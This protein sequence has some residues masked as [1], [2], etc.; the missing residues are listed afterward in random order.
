MARVQDDIQ[1]PLALCR[2]IGLT[3]RSPRAPA[4]PLDCRGVRM[5]IDRPRCGGYRCRCNTRQNLAAGV[6]PVAATSTGRTS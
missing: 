6:T 3:P 5:S 1:R 4:T 2:A